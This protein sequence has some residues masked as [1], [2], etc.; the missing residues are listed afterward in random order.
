MKNII[1]SV[2]GTREFYPEEMALRNWLYGKLR[3]VSQSFGYQEYDGPFLEAIDLYAAKS[4]E[5]LVKEQSFVFPDRGGNLITLR[6]ELTPSL[7][8]MVAQRQNQLVYPLRWWSFGPFWRYEKPQKGRTREFFQWNI[9]LIGVD[10]PEGDAEL[11]A[12]AA[13]FFKAVG[14]SAD[15]VKILVNDR[16]FMEA[17]LAK[18]G[19]E[20][21]DDKKKMIGIID[22][23]DKLSEKDW[24]TYVLESGFTSSH[25][26]GLKNLLNDKSLFKN[27]ETIMRFFS[28][29]QALG[30]E[31]YV[32]YD[33][34]IVRG[35]DYYTGIVFEARDV[36]ESSRAILGGGRYDN[37]VGDVGGSPLAGVG[38]AMGDVVMPLVLEQFGKLPEL[39]LNPAKVLVTVFDEDCLSYSLSIA[40]ALRGAGMNVIIYPEAAKIGKQFKYADRA[41]TRFVIVAGPDERDRKI[42]QVK[43]MQSGEQSSV[44]VEEAVEVIQKLLL[45][46]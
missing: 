34:R 4:G 42:L 5:E 11:V 15:E 25:L 37:L 6:P 18:L 44:G 17:Q 26:E 24:E 1:Q 29:L 16:S 2:K 9:D 30:V 36:S 43:D 23:R 39:E 21:A 28:A 33:P 46:E 8:R 40:A 31:K 27:S 22:K 38:F 35:L 13:E 3:Q 20:N 32:V 45:K 10:S 41:G 7:A 12:I 19:I 14:L